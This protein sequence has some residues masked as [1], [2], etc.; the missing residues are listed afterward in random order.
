VGS[1]DSFDAS[2]WA[3]DDARRSRVARLFNVSARYRGLRR[4]GTARPDLGS[5]AVIHSLILDAEAG[6]HLLWG[7][8]WLAKI[9]QSLD[10]VDALLDAA[11]REIAAVERVTEPRPDPAVPTVSEAASQPASEPTTV[12]ISEHS[13]PV[14]VET[15]STPIDVVEPSFVIVGAEEPDP[16][17]VSDTDRSPAGEAPAVEPAVVATPVVE[18]V[19]VSEPSLSSEASSAVAEPLP[20]EPVVVATPV[21]EPAPISDPA[22]VR[23][24]SA[25]VPAA[26]PATKAGASGKAAPTPKK[27]PAAPA[28]TAPTKTAPT[29]GAQRGRKPPRSP[30]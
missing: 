1:V 18:I 12:P 24:A 6:D 14:F 4:S 21:V 10:V 15:S 25:K 28:K 7:D 17:F 23:P 16:V 5:L 22:P 20:V 3:T 2:R 29:K 27:S 9:D 13:F 19:P 26:K 8:E 11:E 30:A